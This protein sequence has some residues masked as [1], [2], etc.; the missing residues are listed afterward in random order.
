MSKRANVGT[1][2][3]GVLLVMLLGACSSGGDV[4]LTLRTCDIIA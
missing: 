1:V 4:K 3:T 2:F